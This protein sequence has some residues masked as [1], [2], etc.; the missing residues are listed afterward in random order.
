MTAQTVAT[1]KSYFV[2]GA[3][4]TQ[5]QFAN[6]MDSY[7]SFLD[8]S[9]QSIVSDFV[10][11]GGVTVSGAASIGGALTSLS[12]VIGAPTGGNKGNGTLNATGIYVNGTLITTTSA[13]GSGTVNSGTAGQIAFYNT[14]SNSVS[15]TNAVPNGTTATTQTLADASTKVSS[16]QFV[17]NN[18]G[19][20]KQTAKAWC[21]FDGTATGTNAPQAGFNV[22]SVTRNSTG[23]YTINFT[24]AMADTNYAPASM[25]GNGLILNPITYNTG[26]FVVGNNAASNGAFTDNTNLSLIFFGD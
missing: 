22:T 11:G 19:S 4:P 18:I 16:N 8:T 10:I 6:V 26:S 9:A 15:G 7:V 1:L 25:T 23:N 5:A 17:M 12:A 21:R 20:N 2:T 24:N 3:K 13:G 14:T